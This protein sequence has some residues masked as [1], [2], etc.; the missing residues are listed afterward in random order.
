MKAMFKIY[1]LRLNYK[2]FWHFGNNLYLGCSKSYEPRKIKIS[3]NLKK[4]KYIITFY[5]YFN[6]L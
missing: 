6:R 1:C 5:Y 4:R 2:T 3:Y